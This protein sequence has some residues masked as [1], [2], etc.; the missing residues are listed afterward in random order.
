MI[1][2]IASG[3][4]NS[5]QDEG[6]FGFRAQGVSTTGAMDQLSMRVA[7]ILV[8]NPETA[9][10]LEIQS[11]PFRIRFLDEHRFAVAGAAAPMTLEGRALPSNWSGSTCAGDELEIGPPT[12]GSRSYV[13]VAGGLDIPEVLGSLSTYMRNHFGGYQ[14]RE[15]RAGDRIGVGQ[16]GASGARDGGLISPIASLNRRG[17]S[18]KA[19]TLRVLPGADYELFSGEQRDAFWSTE[20]RI[21]PQ[22]NRSGFRLRGEALVLSKPVSLYSYGVVPGIS[23]VPPS[24]DPII[25]LADAN[26][27]GGYPRFGGVIEA[28]LWKLGQA[29]IGSLLQFTQVDFRAA[30]AALAELDSYLATVREGQRLMGILAASSTNSDGQQI[31]RAAP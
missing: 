9:A 28:D 10:V 19:L 18:G 2:V 13:A 27:A 1:E 16:L 24:G 20:W 17:G 8:G 30:A 11:F 14:G 15:L 25:Q 4:V 6:R 3:P 31:S 7:N 23:Q 26:T 29:P 5:V 12:Q 21:T 22:S